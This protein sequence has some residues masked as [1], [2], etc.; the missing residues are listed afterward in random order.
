M[1]VFGAYLF[2]MFLAETKRCSG[3]PKASTDGID[4]PTNKNTQRAVVG[5]HQE[6]GG[7]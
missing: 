5:S 3:V 1:P 4:K 7:C 6:L 2:S